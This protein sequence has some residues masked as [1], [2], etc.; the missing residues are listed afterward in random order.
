MKKILFILMLLCSCFLL[1][2]C[3]DPDPDDGYTA[4]QNY[5]ILF[6]ALFYWFVVI[7]GFGTKNPI[8]MTIATIMTIIAAIVIFQW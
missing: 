5:G 6:F 8:V 4:E 2:S 7:C 1:S 3:E